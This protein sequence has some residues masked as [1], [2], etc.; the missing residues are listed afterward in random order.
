MSDASFRDHDLQSPGRQRLE[1]VV[2]LGIAASIFVA[3]LFMG[4]RGP[5]GRFVFITIVCISAAAWCLRQ[6]LSQRGSW[7]WSGAEWL[8]MAGLGVLLLQLVPLPKPVLELLSPGAGK[9]LPLWMGANDASLAIGTWTQASLHPAATQAGLGV[10]VAYALLF[11]LA[12]QRLGTLEDIHR[13]LKLIACATCF[14]TVV[15]LL[16]FLFGNGKFLW[17][18]EHSSRTTSDIVRGTFQ[19]QNHLAQ[20]LALGIGPILWWISTLASGSS[21]SGSSASGSSASGSSGRSRSSFS[22]GRSRSLRS[23][24]EFLT[25]A[26]WVA[27]GVVIFAALLT[28]SRGGVIAVLLASSVALGIIV[29][30]QLLG[31]RGVLAIGVVAGLMFLA[32]GVFGY[33]PLAR[34]LG[35]LR[36]SSSLEELSSG[37]AALWTSHTKIIPNFWPLGTGV[38]THR[39]IYPTFLDKHFDVEF[40]HG[41]SSYMQLLVETGLLGTGLVLFGLFM[42]FR[43]AI[44][45]FTG[46][47][48]SALAAAS[49]AV[50]PGLV[51]SVLHSFGDFVWYIPACMTTT[52]LIV[53]V[54]FRLR[55]LVAEEA[56]GT[57]PDSASGTATN[58]I[59]VP[60]LGFAGATVI[61]V[62]LA[63]LATSLTYRPAKS[64][65]AWHAYRRLARED[66]KV[67]ADRT[68][69]DRL[70]AMGGHLEKTISRD[71]SN[72]R[73]H[74]HLAGIYLQRFDIEQLTAANPM[75]LSQIRDAA[76]A[77]QFPSRD[78]M[79]QWIDRAVGANRQWIDKALEHAR[80]GVMLSPLQGEGYTFLAS[81]AFLES[82]VEE[83]KSAYIQQALATR[84][85]DGRVLYVAGQEALLA[86]DVEQ[87]LDLWKQAFH[88][89]K[90]IRDRLLRE[91]STIIPAGELL[92]RFDPDIPGCLALHW[93]YSAR[94]DAAA[95]QE[96]A[97]YCIPKLEALTREQDGRRLAG[98]L[99]RLS[100]FYFATG[101]AQPGLAALQKSAE[102]DPS[103]FETRQEL[104]KQL[105]AASRATEALEHLQW[106]SLRRPD[107]KATQDMLARANRASVLEQAQQ[108][109]SDP[110]QI[111]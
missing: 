98:T 33:E 20:L 23:N 100:E 28:F 15:A 103:H 109:P 47:P 32:L 97:L 63:V 12:Y 35:T 104:A 86:G 59:A 42:I 36:Q 74:V 105:L 95:A 92:S 25:Q 77:S 14:A 66:Q 84:P 22:S 6:A 56:R 87:A 38:G 4:G 61:C 16:Q 52:I 72:A 80:Q 110:A 75:P 34:K 31:R 71:P 82:P 40:T 7:R 81:L 49:I 11:L 89:E 65:L 53:A 57:T 91:L 85:H 111:R 21:A 10:Y 9:L 58:V 67:T 60:Q 106:C 73:A 76:L 50:V 90:E 93:H 26:L 62:A 99:R 13:L 5:L 8:L 69:V 107:D 83:R 2:D 55:D 79:N 64:A 43:A 44:P 101:A 17:I 1:A 78:A 88:Q 18:F 96:T 30:K 54:A 3:P 48:P 24:P 68:S 37:R 94:G 29:W 39:D 19:N 41:E 46:T 102:A 27:F 51:A 108:P 70:A 45:L